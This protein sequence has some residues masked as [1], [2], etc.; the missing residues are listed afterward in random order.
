[1]PDELKKVQARN[2]R[3]VYNYA[4]PKYPGKITLFKASHRNVGVVDLPAVTLR[5]N[6]QI[7]SGIHL[8]KICTVRILQLELRN[9]NN[10]LLFGITMSIGMLLE[11]KSQKWWRDYMVIAM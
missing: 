9:L 6:W 4:A 11:K 7:P 5:Q 8:V 3:T 1:M 10:L 2:L